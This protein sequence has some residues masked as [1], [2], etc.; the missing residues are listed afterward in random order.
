MIYKSQFWKIDT[1][2][3]FVVPGHIYRI[4]PAFHLSITNHV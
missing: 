4:T 3:G 1:Y 2:A